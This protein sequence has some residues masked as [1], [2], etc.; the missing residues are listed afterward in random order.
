RI[1][2]A[3]A[4]AF[5]N[6]EELWVPSLLASHDGTARL[7]SIL[8]ASMRRPGGEPVPALG[9]GD[10]EAER[11][12]WSANLGALASRVSGEADDLFALA[13][14]HPSDRVRA[15]AAGLLGSHPGSRTRELLLK[16]VADRS[17]YVADAALRGLPGAPWT[18]EVF[19][20][21]MAHTSYSVR[22]Q[23]VK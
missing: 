4:A 14:E 18:L 12:F 23:A 13:L 3:A 6:L 8:E 21:A 20:K 16:A 22:A 5:P 17:E 19:E 10:E 9:D 15:M 1:L 2:D 7:A 11:N